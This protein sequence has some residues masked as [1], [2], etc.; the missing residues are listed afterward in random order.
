VG[1]YPGELAELPEQG[2]Q[3]CNCTALYCAALY[4]ACAVVV[5]TPCSVAL[6]CAALCYAVPC[7]LLALLST[8][9]QYQTHPSSACTAAADV[10]C[11][12]QAS[13]MA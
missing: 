7:D 13:C 11:R 2:R 4:S 5:S 6:C 3:M 10:H 1:I 8:M 12:D 9:A